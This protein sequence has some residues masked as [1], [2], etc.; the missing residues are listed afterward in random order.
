MIELLYRV[1]GL[2]HRGGVVLMV[3]EEVRIIP[4]EEIERARMEAELEPETDINE[5]GEQLQKLNLRPKPEDSMEQVFWAMRNQFPEMAEAFN[6][7]PR[8][9]GGKMMRVAG[10]SFVS[11]L[12]EMHITPEQYVEMGSPPLLS[13]I[14][15]SMTA[16][17]LGT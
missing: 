10:P 6:S 14:K 9:G 17:S 11:S 12:T 5:E 13:I 8:M 3:L 16:L 15:F 1:V 2:S 7:A 4:P